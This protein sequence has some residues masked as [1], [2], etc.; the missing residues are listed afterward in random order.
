M[1][2]YALLAT[3]L[4]SMISFGALAQE[5]VVDKEKYLE[6]KIEQILDNSNLSLKEKTE[7]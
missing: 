6:E 1:K 2:K 3:I 4:F 5:E 7:V